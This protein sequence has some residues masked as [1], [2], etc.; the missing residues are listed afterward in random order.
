M[1]TDH[2]ERI[3]R[4]AGD[5]EALGEM[6]A[7]MRE[8]QTL[9]AGMDKARARVKEIQ[10]VTTEVMAKLDPAREELAAAQAEARRLRSDTAQESIAQAAAAA[11]RANDIRARAEADAQAVA[12]KAKAE[13]AAVVNAAL[14]E[15]K[16]T[17]DGAQRTK[18][19]LDVEIRAKSLESE[20]LGREIE[21][22][23][24]QVAQLDA[25]LAAVFEKAAELRNAG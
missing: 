4:L 13:A 18:A 24:A 25:R 12:E 21:Q 11:D 20:R 9:E 14:V 7:A 6:L 15:A 8:M 17:R 3:E 2:L 23:A 19:G 1:R 22:K 5:A 16:A 10:D